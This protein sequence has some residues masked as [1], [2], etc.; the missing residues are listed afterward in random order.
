VQLF[1]IVKIATFVVVDVLVHDDI[2]E[3]H[4]DACNDFAYDFVVYD[5]EIDE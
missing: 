2:A 5:I 1:V 3:R 4:E